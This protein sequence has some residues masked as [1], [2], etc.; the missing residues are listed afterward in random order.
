M[1][2]CWAYLPSKSCILPARESIFHVFLVFRHSKALKGNV[3]K[4][5]VNTAKIRLFGIIL[6]LWNAADFFSIFS[7][8]FVSDALVEK[9]GPSLS[10]NSASITTRCMGGTKITEETEKK[11]NQLKM[12]IFWH[13]GPQE[14]TKSTDET[15]TKQINLKQMNLR[16]EFFDTHKK[17]ERAQKRQKQS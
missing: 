5:L 11:A 17:A 13:Q 10:K 9:S 6:V 8:I 14:D 16:W 3:H 7:V 15:K 12:R 1:G 4:T 2:L